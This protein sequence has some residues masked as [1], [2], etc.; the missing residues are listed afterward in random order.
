MSDVYRDVAFTE[1]VR[2]AQEQYGS[3]AAMSRLEH[4]REHLPA[5]EDGDA[6]T[7]MER[8]FISE[9]DGF[10]LASVSD[11]GWPYVQFASPL[12]NAYKLS[13]PRTR[14]CEKRCAP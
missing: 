9:R 6:L 12:S 5:D 10:Y 2:A 4:H 1:H 3:R 14:G 13:R 7:E 11:S 8:D